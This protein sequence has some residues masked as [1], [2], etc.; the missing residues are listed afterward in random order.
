MSIND[1]LHS[2]VFKL[3]KLSESIYG[4]GNYNRLGAIKNGEKNITQA[5]TQKIISFFEKKFGI[6]LQNR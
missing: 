5:D 3:N 4:K 6:S 1:I 2:G